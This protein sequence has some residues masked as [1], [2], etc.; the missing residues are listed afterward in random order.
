M[1]SV[2]DNRCEHGK[3]PQFC[4]VCKV[5]IRERNRTKSQQATG[6]KTPQNSASF[7]GHTWDQ[8]FEMCD[9]GT[10][11]ILDC[12][13]RGGLILY[14]DL[15]QA[16]QTEIEWDIGHP[17]RQIP[18]L[19]EYISDRTYEDLGI[20]ITALAVDGVGGNHG[21]SEGFF[22]LAASRGALPES[23]SPPIGMPWTGMTP[24]QRRF[25]REQVDMIRQ[26]LSD[27]N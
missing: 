23:D 7:F 25:W 20:F 24:N 21:P 12:A 11:V 5:K 14:S 8:W 13:R 27:G 10:R 18:F 16:I 15:W 6:R 4:S 2:F 22:R 9:V 3:I 1:G 19:L 17:W 26:K